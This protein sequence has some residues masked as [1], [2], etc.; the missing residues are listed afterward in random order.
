MFA[1][2]LRFHWNTYLYC[3]NIFERKLGTSFFVCFMT[4]AAMYSDVC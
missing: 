1:V 3:K 4:I 2:I